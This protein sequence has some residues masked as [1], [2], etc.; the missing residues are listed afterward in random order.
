MFEAFG[1]QSS[2][3]ADAVSGLDLGASP[4]C[5]GRGAGRAR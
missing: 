3:G 4:A 2:A 5:G 1:T